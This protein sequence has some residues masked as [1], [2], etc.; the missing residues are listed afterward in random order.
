MGWQDFL[1]KHGIGSPGYVAR[2][3]AKQYR[4]IKEADPSMDERA[5][6]IRVYANRVAA[7]SILEGP[8]EY[9]ECR[10]DPSLMRRAID[11][12]PNLF[13]IIRHAILIEH[14]ELDNPRAPAD[15]FEVLDRVLAEILDRETSGWR[16]T[17]QCPLHEEQT[18]QTEQPSNLNLNAT[19]LYGAILEQGLSVAA[20][21]DRFLNVCAE[22]SP[23]TLFITDEWIAPRFQKLRTLLSDPI[24][25]DQAEALNDAILKQA[26]L[27]DVIEWLAES[28]LS[29][30]VFH[31]HKR[32]ATSELKRLRSE[33]QR[34]EY[35]RKFAAAQMAWKTKANTPWEAALRDL[36]FQA[37]HDSAAAKQKYGG[38]AQPCP[39]CKSID[40]AWFYFVTPPPPYEHQWIHGFAGWETACQKCN[41]EVDFF[42]EAR[43]HY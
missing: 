27:D 25:Y 5:V 36:E 39:Q 23:D 30:R 35:Q 20:A 42:P 24:T 9:R 3:M 43:I 40:L 1:M 29:W 18:G 14:P 4:A 31:K 38:S 33:E 10:K 28:A 19:Q 11:Q 12:N 22:E 34:L 26:K 17:H 41:I 21:L 16:R 37:R 32:E 13:S 7:Q 15:R 8:A 2:V 6:L